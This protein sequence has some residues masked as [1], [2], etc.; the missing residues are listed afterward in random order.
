MRFILLSSLCVLI[1]ADIIAQQA[2]FRSQSANLNSYSV[3]SKTSS[4]ATNTKPFVPAQDT[5][6]QITKKKL[7]PKGV[8]NPSFATFWRI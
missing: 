1:S 2:V 8:N 7:A 6:T 4:S 5:P 3:P